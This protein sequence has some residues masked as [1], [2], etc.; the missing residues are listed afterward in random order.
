MALPQGE[1]EA[2]SMGAL[3]AMDNL[4]L[5]QLADPAKLPGLL[6]S[7]YTQQM[8]EFRNAEASA[9]ARF[10]EGKA[11]IAERYQGP[12]Q[13]E[14]L[15]ML[16]KALL[17]P[18]DYRGFAGTIGKISGALGGI[19]DAE[20]KARQQRD[21]Q[22]AALQDSYAKEAAGFGVD[23][24]QTAAD[25]VKTAAPLLK[26]PALRSALNSR[27]EVVNLN[28]AEVI[29]PPPPPVGTTKVFKGRKYT[30]IGGD[31][32]DKNNWKVGK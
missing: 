19:S 26:P 32:Y 29:N 1:D 16:S 25:L 11:R 30:F 10:E 2:E 28:T 31:Q 7:L 3:A 13:S 18:R 22:L 8:G 27:D 6:Q 12:S 9:K 23:R 14:Q 4:D 20:S 24:A 17:A 21:A 5:T 15:L